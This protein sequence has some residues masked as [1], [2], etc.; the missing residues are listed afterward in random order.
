MSANTDFDLELP[1][2]EELAVDVSNTAAV[3]LEELADVVE[4]VSDS[5]SGTASSSQ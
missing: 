1:R 4:A 2:T 5:S 3:T